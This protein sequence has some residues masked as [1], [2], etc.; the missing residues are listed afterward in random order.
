MRTF[1]GFGE[2]AKL[3]AENVTVV[4]AMR[5]AMEADLNAFADA[6]VE[7]VRE[8]V[9]PLEFGHQVV[10]H[11]GAWQQMWAFVPEENED[12]LPW[13]TF[14]RQSARF[15]SPGE[16]RGYLMIP[17]KDDG[18][19]KKQ[20][21]EL[22]E[23]PDLS[24]FGWQKTKDGW[25]VRTLIIPFGSSDPIQAVTPAYAATLRAMVAVRRQD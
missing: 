12:D 2:A 1:S 6:L 5:D 22:V 24:R 23:R 17:D 18:P 10:T 20:L 16:F 21:I 15:I 13:I 25:A 9:R 8:A 14:K 3:Y 11:T 7:A 19:M 4:E